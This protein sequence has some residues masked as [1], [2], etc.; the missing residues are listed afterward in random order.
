[1]L[2]RF[3]GADWAAALGAALGLISTFVPWYSYSTG[4]AH[5]SV[6]GFRASIL[7]DLFYLT[8]AA[9][10]LLLLLRHQAIEEPLA[11][12]IREDSAF[13]ALAGGAVAAVLLQLILSATGGRNVGPGLLMAVIA[14]IV[15]AAGAW[16]RRA[17][18]QPRRTVP[19]TFT[20]GDL[21]D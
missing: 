17:E 14:A 6:N 10:V 2:R 1:M 19:E 15:L 13:L 3:T 8:I 12:L 16:L 5:I 20:G 9:T 18:A 7:G 11:A 4:T 21:P